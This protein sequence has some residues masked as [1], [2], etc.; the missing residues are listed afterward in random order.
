MATIIGNGLLLTNLSKEPLL[1]DG[2]VAVENG[3]ITKVGSTTALKA[4]FPECTFIDAKGK[5]IMPGIV[6]NHHHFYSALAR[7][8]IT[9]NPQVSKDFLDILHNLWWKLDGALTLES[10]RYSAAVSI[11]D[12][13]K[14][15][16]TSIV[17]HHAGFGAIRG[18]LEAIAK[19]AQSMG[20]RSCL[21]FEVSDRAGEKAALESIEENKSFL[22]SLTKENKEMVAGLFGL[23][24]SFTV[25]DTTLKA[26]KKAAG[27]SGFHVHVAEGLDDVKDALNNHGK[28]VVE[29]LY[30]FGILGTKTLAIHCIH[31]SPSEMELLAETNTTV[32]HNPQSNMSNA[33]GCSP[34]FELLKH[35]V[36]VGLGTDAYTHD[37]F[38]SA[39]A[40]GLL[41][42]H[43]L[44]DPSIAW[45]EPYTLLLKNNPEIAGEI[46]DTRLGVLEAGAAADIIVVDYDPLTPLLPENITGHI[47]FGLSGSMVQT[48]MIN[49]K[50]VMRDRE[51]LT[52][53]EKQLRAESR[54]VAAALWKSL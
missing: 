15:G 4:D 31:V 19:T 46:F 22:D 36:R 14:C 10:T 26:S 39:K 33:V 7:G 49:G 48:S 20:V 6:N 3:R 25:S 27:D 34:L 2:A 9:K 42:R 17:D 12:S 28:R 5:V 13:I 8:M 1:D 32:I 35:G 40:A 16:V 50:L 38:E 47:H 52:V 11:A 51:L 21:C 24:A 53:D 23:H 41:Q 18:S 54:K 43:H 45:G 37:M 29:R 44:G 30:D